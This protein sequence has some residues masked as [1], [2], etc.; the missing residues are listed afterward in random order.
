MRALSMG[1]TDEGVNMVKDGRP[2][3][4]GKETP[5]DESNRDRDFR[6]LLPDTGLAW[7][8]PTQ[9]FA[10]VIANRATTQCE[11]QERSLE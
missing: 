3:G 4:V 7:A 11:G 10:G 5:R 9:D 6:F 8:R 2:A 1:D